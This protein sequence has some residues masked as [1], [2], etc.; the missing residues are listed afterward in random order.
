MNFIIKPKA[1]EFIRQQ[2]GVI[3]AKLEKRMSFG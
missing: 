3:Q 2:G 1:Q